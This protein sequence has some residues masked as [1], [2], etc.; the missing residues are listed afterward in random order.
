MRCRQAPAASDKE[1][2]PGKV[3]QEFFPDDDQGQG[4]MKEENKSQCYQVA[5]SQS[6]GSP[7]EREDRN[8]FVAKRRLNI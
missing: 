3:G 5:E 8:R 6:Y 1:G 7:Q 4:P 2:K